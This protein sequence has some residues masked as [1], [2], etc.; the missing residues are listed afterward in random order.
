MVQVDIY[1]LQEYLRD[2]IQKILKE[3]YCKCNYDGF[4]VNLF[5]LVRIGWVIRDFKGKF[6]EL[7]YVIGNNVILVLEVEL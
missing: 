2:N 1:V 3:G 5:I 7:G 4:F 6:F